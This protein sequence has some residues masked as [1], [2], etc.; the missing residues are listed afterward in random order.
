MLSFNN[1]FGYL[2]GLSRGYRGEILRAADYSNL[3]QCDSLDGNASV[4]RAGK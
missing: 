4:R 2:E 1:E 3:L